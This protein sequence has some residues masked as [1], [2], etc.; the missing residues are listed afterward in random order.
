MFDTE[1]YLGQHNSHLDIYYD[2]CNVFYAL[3]MVHSWA[4][5]SECS[6]IFA[7]KVSIFFRYFL[8]FACKQ[9]GV[10]PNRAM[11]GCKK[12]QRMKML[13]VPNIFWN[14]RL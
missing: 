13:D 11:L 4:L 10:A 6:S 7:S 14:Y 2:N 1:R 5:D 12:I 8:R 3:D 9:P